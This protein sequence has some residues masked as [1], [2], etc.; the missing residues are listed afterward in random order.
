MY[1]YIE[2]C[3][4]CGGTIT[5]VTLTTN[6]PITR[7]ICTKCNRSWTKKPAIVSVVFDPDKQGYTEDKTTG[8][9]I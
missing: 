7:K 1:Q 2:K 3:P 6:P 9:Q 5:S 8:G 4:K